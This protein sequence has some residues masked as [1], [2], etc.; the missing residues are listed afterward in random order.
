MNHTFLWFCN[1]DGGLVLLCDQVGLCLF[2]STKQPTSQDKWPQKDYW[3][4]RETRCRKTKEPSHDAPHDLLHYNGSGDLRGVAIMGSLSPLEPRKWTIQDKTNIGS[5]T[6]FH[7]SALSPLSHLK[8]ETLSRSR[9]RMWHLHNMPAIVTLSHN[10][11]TPTL[12]LTNC[13]ISW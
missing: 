2:A 11:Q 13:I 1:K 10:A 9:S 6:T 5:Y 3:Q 8:M 12:P 7:K 4:S